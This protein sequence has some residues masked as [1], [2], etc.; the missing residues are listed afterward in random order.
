VLETN[1]ANVNDAEADPTIS[2]L[3]AKAA[4]RAE[5][6]LVIVVLRDWLYGIRRVLG[7]HATFMPNLQSPFESKLY[8]K[9]PE[10]LCDRCKKFQ[11]NP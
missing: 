3:M 1:G 6:F 8:L 5:K 7:S 11:R 9:L 2:A 4:I 10:N